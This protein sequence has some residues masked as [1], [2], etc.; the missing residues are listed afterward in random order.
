MGVVLRF[1][2]FAGEWFVEWLAESGGYALHVN[3][4]PLGSFTYSDERFYTHDEAINRINMF[5]IP[6]RYTLVRSEQLLSVIS[7]VDE[8]SIRQLDSM[9]RTV[10]EITPSVHAAS[11]S[12]AAPSFAIPAS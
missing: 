5:L 8:I 2:R 1:A 3:D 7:L 12:T 11:T 10:E 9:A 4:L 6:Q